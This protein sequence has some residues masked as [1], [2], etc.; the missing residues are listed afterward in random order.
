DFSVD[1]SGGSAPPLVLPCS[2]ADRHLPE[3]GPQVGG[4]TGTIALVPQSH[5]ERVEDTQDQV[6]LIHRDSLRVAQHSSGELKQ[7]RPEAFP[8]PRE[9]FLVTLGGAYHPARDGRSVP[10]RREGRGDRGWSLWGLR[11]GLCGGGGRL[12]RGRK[13]R[14]RE[15]GG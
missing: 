7:A 9:C 13:G 1:I 12:P 14:R 15:E 10:L 11:E 2:F 3:Q 6:F 5:M 8:K 4:V